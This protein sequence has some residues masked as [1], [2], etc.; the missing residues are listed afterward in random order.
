MSDFRG[1]TIKSTFQRLIQLDESDGGT[2]RDGTGSAIQH[3]GLQKYIELGEGTLAPATPSSGKG[4]L[5]ASSSNTLHYKN[6]AGTVYNLVLGDTGSAQDL[7]QDATPQLG[8][9]LDLNSKDIIG[10]GDVIVTGSAIFSGSGALN[11]KGVHSSSFF[12]HGG[13]GVSN[14]IGEKGGIF[15]GDYKNDGDSSR[16]FYTGTTNNNG[17][18]IMSSSNDLELFSKDD[19]LLRS[20]DNITLNA[21]DDI[22]METGGGSGDEI[23]LVAGGNLTISASGGGASK[24]SITVK[25]DLPNTWPNTTFG[26]TG[27][28][29]ITGSTSVVGSVTASSNISSSGNIIGSSTIYKKNTWA[30]SDATPSVLNGTYWESG[31]AGVTVTTMDDGQVGQVVHVISKAAIVYDVTSTTLKCGTTN[32]TTAAGDLTSWLFDGTNWTCIGFTD[33]SDDLS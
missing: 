14:P 4:R 7:A 5:F 17:K 18:L 12:V 6:D 24:P 8:G 9:N 1:K 3:I 31:T 32:L 28:T 30:N 25:S 29:T 20:K 15:F 21:S 13:S 11:T 16:I 22:R 10:V 19:L 23:N 27:I 33:Q 2:L 26:V